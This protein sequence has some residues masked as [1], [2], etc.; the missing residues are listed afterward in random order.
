VK[1]KKIFFTEL[2]IEQIFVEFYQKNKEKSFL[3]AKSFLIGDAEKR[4]L[5]CKKIFNSL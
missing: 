5:I 1:E 2:W 3:Q 4:L